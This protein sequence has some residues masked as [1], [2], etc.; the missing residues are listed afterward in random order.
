MI[1]DSIYSCPAA[2][3]PPIHCRL[4]LKD[5][6]PHVP[7]NQMRDQFGPASDRRY[8]IGT[9]QRVHD[10]INVAK[11]MRSSVIVKSVCVLIVLAVLL[12]LVYR[13]TNAEIANIA[14]GVSLESAEKG[15]I[16]FIILSRVAGQTQ[17]NQPFYLR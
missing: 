8:F 11:A 2:L 12:L 4:R 14:S 7:A 10:V 13:R 9:V 15:S 17:T 16:T 3:H 6:L 5:H 1:R